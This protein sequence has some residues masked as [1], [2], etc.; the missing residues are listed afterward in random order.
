MIFW[1]G[2][3]VAGRI[4]SREAGPF[5][6]AFLRF[7]VASF[8]LLIFVMRS[9]EKAPR[10]EAGQILLLFLLGLSGVFAYNFLFFSGLQTVPAGRASLIIAANPAFIALVSGLIFGERLGIVRMLGILVS[11]A[12]AAVVISRGDPAVLLRG[13]LGVGELFILGCVASWVTYSILGKVALRNTTPLLAVTCA[14]VMGAA[15]LFFPAFHEGVLSKAG[16]LSLSVWLAIFFLGFFGSALG[17][18][19][20]YEGIRAIGA[21][22][23]GV[24]I[25]LVPVS[26]VL[27]AFFLLNEG[28]DFSLLLG[29]ALIIAGVY[30]TNRPRPIAA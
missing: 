9:D 13:K 27:L 7:A 11:A 20:Y 24:F 22:R 17:F 14:C 5:S 6:A 1:G 16:H 29:G 18:V 15:C 28:V 2:T 19:W 4:V 12:G 21:S 23:A 8:F 3:F 10:F 26:S 30:F 25:N